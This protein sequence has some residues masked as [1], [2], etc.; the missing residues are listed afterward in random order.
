VADLLEHGGKREEKFL[1]EG[2]K[3][4]G[5]IFI[6]SVHIYVPKTSHD[7][8]PVVPRK[9]GGK[10]GQKPNGRKKR[11]ERISSPTIAA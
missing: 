6:K 10:G 4:M 11:G 8:G 3:E 9:E 7:A 2:G 1:R 5:S